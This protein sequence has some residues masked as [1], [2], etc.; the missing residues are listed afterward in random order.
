[1]LE[2]E[3]IQVFTRIFTDSMRDS[4]KGKNVNDIYRLHISRHKK[5]G[6][7][8]YIQANFRR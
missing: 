5:K 7:T 8:L 2:S 3:F 6:I 4:M 1:M